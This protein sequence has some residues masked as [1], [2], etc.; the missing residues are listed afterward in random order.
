MSNSANTSARERF[1][2]PFLAAGYAAVDPPV[3]QPAE[4]MLDLLGEDLGRRLYLTTDA[5]GREWCLR[6]EMTL[7]VCRLHLV[8][9]SHERLGAYAYHG[10]VFRQRQGAGVGEFTQAG[11]ELLGRQDSEQA[12]A[13]I[14]AFA[15]DVARRGGLA[16]P[17]VR[18]GDAGLFR[19]FLGALD[20][21]PSWRRRLSRAFGRGQLLPHTLPELSVQRKGLAKEGVLGA[22]AGADRAGARALVE[23]LL[24]IGGL[25]AVGGRSVAEIADR[26]LEQAEDAA[27]GA[28]PAATAQAIAEYLA[29]S[30]PADQSVARLD[31]LLAS[32]RLDL[33][34]ARASLTLRL[35]A[36]EDARNGPADLVLDF[37]FGRRLDYYSGFVFEVEAEAAKAQPAIGGGRYDGLVTLLGAPTPVP[38]VG[39]SVWID[40][41]AGAGA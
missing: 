39:F 5:E 27:G 6:P 12:D 21:T 22:L 7:P 10:A 25:Q 3:L 19:A 41:L 16:C 23:D 31:A 13:E 9:G 24:A 32:H 26:F 18:M 34:R 38:A 2:A 37:G 20:L 8:S 15:L 4:L 17:V 14:L 33:G 40:R 28:L 1:L 30:G 35:R 11:A 36:I 29:I